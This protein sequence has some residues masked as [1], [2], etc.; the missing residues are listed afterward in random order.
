M[1]HRFGIGQFLLA[2]LAS[3]TG[4]TVAT[5][6]STPQESL[7]QSKP[8]TSVA[9][10]ATLAVINNDGQHIGSAVSFQ[11]K[12]GAH[13]AVT[14]QHVVA[15][16]AS[17]CLMSRSGKSYPFSII[18]LPLDKRH[19]MHMDI[20]FLKAPLETTTGLTTAELQEMKSSQSLT[21]PIVVATGYPTSAQAKR[22]MPPLHMSKGLL[23]PLLERELE[24]GYDTTYTAHIEKG[25]SGGGVF[26]DERLVAINGAHSDPLWNFHWKDRYGK[27]VDASLNEKL[28]L[29]SI[30]I[31]MRRILREFKRVDAIKAAHS[32]IECRKP[33]EVKSLSSR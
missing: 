25:M 7:V 28:G 14:N 2:A 21:F 33:K 26:I 31:S 30:G 10:D 9:E 12:D 19:P 18:Q 3:V 23:V 17:V 13:W 22:Q 5:S 6:S 20:A 29:L 32:D 4:I 1:M 24:E 15:D 11:R 27:P 8:Q 16:H